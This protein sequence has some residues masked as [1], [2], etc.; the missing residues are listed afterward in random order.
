MG[1]HCMGCFLIVLQNE[2]RTRSKSILF[3]EFKIETITVLYACSFDLYDAQFLY[4]RTAK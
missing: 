3:A 1:S 4:F 2:N